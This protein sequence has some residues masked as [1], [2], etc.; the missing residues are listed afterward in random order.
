MYRGR[1]ESPGHSLRIGSGPPPTLN[2]L[3]AH[4]CP[5][6]N[7]V[8]NSMHHHHPHHHQQHSDMIDHVSDTTLP[9]AQMECSQPRPSEAIPCS[10]P[11]SLLL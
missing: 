6:D 4:H 10:A 8:D 9:P 5:Q 11:L 7:H 2:P 3:P 1:F